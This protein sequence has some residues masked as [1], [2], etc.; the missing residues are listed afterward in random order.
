M[1]PPI[2]DDDSAVKDGQT[3]VDPDDP[4]AIIAK[5]SANADDEY[6]AKTSDKNYYSIAHTLRET[7][8]Q[9][10]SLL[11]FG[12]LKEYQVFNESLL[13]YNCIFQL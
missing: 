3:T 8:Q 9:Q 6:S 12:T 13:W 1:S 5:A 4:K 11:S 7:I 10:P 2:Q